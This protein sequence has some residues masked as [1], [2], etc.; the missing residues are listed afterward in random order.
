[1]RKLVSAA[2]SAF[3]ILAI[4]AGATF[5]A[6]CY[7]A[8]KPVGAGAMND[9]GHGAFF[10]FEGIDFFV[11]PD[12][13]QGLDDTAFGKALPD[14]ARGSGP[15]DGCGYGVDSYETCVLGE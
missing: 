11:L 8:N 12:S 9:D 6:D 13:A 3:A 2:L 14:G 7:L 10:T 15:G 4:S 5:A 1:M